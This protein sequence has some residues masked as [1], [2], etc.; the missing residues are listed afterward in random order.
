MNLPIRN[1]YV[2]FCAFVAL[3][4]LCGCSPEN[5]KAKFLSQADEHFK[6]G[7]Y[8]LA[9][10]D[11]KNALQ[12]EAENP[13]AIAQLGT[14]YFEQGRLLM[15][16][17][18]LSRASKLQ[19]ANFEVL[20]N[21]IKTDLTF[22]D[23]AAAKTN[24]L[25]ILE[26]S[27]QNEDGPMLLAQSAT[28]PA[29]IQEARGII[30]KLPGGAGDSASANLALGILDLRENK[31]DEAE[32]AF[33]KSA[34]INPKFAEAH[35]ALAS[36][37]L[38]KKD[39]IKAEVELKAAAELSAPRS[40]KRLEY[41]SF[42]SQKGDTAAAKQLLQKLV[43]EAP[44]YLP[45]L[46][47]MAQFASVEKKYDESLAVI[48]KVLAKDSR[49]PEAMLL[50][51]RLRMA[52]GEFAVAIAELEKALGIFATS[53]QFIYQLGLAQV[54]QG[55]MRKAIET[56]NRALK[57]APNYTE[58]S[59]L[60]AGLNMRT[61][62]PSSAIVSLKIVVQQHP[63]LIQPRL[64]L[65]D[66]YRGQGNFND[67][68]AVFEGIEK[69]FP[70][71]QRTPL[72]AGQVY[73]QQ[74]RWKEARAAL[75]LS[76][77]RDPTSQTTIEQLI[78]LEV[79][80]NKFTE[81]H[82]LVDQ[83]IEKKPK[84]A[85]NYVT[86]ARVFLAQKDSAKAEESLQKSI[87][88]QPDAWGTYFMLAQLYISTSQ[89]QK[90]IDNLQ[91]IL[92]ANPKDVQS[93]TLLALVNDQL[94]RYDAALAAYE[95]ILEV[96][97][98]SGIALNNVAFLYADRF[99]QLD[100]ALESAQKA[101]DLFPKDAN[102]ADTL[103]WVLVRKGQYGR[104]IVLLEE[105]A[106]KLPK[107]AEIQY[108][109]GVAYYQF[110]DEAAAKSALELA[111]KSTESYTWTDDAKKRLTFLSTDPKRSDTAA[112]QALEKIVANNPSDTVALIRLGE[113]QEQMGDRSAAIA[114]HEAALKLSPTN[115]DVMLR[116]IRIYRAQKESEKAI[117]IAKT[118]R[119]AAPD[120]IAVAI[121]LGGLAFEARDFG[122]S[123]S[124]LQEADRKQPNNASTLRDLAKAGYS[125]GQIKET[126]G[127]LTRSLE[128]D[129]TSPA[130]LKAKEFLRNIDLA[131]TA[132]AGIDPKV[133]K[134]FEAVANDV[135]AMMVTAAGLEQKR[136]LSDAI[137]K[138]EKVL[139]IYPDF[140]PAKR[141]LAI[142][143]T[144]KDSDL[145]KAMEY[146]NKARSVYA[147]D[148]ELTK[149]FGILLHRQGEFARVSTLFKELAVK[150]KDDAEIQFY[151]GSAQAKLGN[152]APAQQYLNRALQL[153][154]KPDLATEAQKLLSD[155]K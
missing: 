119:K 77:K 104:A 18:Y 19:P 75:D 37:Y 58:A 12:Q 109:L 83:L 118:A 29:S 2:S 33:T 101:R 93:L 62:D 123:L 36:I 1:A 41:I 43:Q 144:A 81:A 108:H 65:A 16:K 143:L 17:P 124:L 5:K 94:K 84:A 54:A 71:N 86:R 79:T 9:E 125:V 34:A 39:L 60:L 138:Y 13:K 88:L 45:A 141:R 56:L 40:S 146:A 105:S 134:S 85:D 145:K 78:A 113:I 30:K 151:L 149:A 154:L 155:L 120:N 150:L 74:K 90:A 8:D 142:L 10:I 99:N 15:A 35:T 148:T 89:Q 42:L 106:E 61:G 122:Y 59:V 72:L 132:L 102:V 127:A 147:D 46:M 100:K 76:L 95:K 47:L 21:L 44:D 114:S 4:V 91:R 116:L 6:V 70:G 130:A 25:L 66:A 133:L 121:A 96:N 7:K 140:T 115:V 14:I 20:S 152:K 112:R 139:E 11:Y 129:G 87:E 57:I 27:P 135:P 107:S 24:A 49:Y 80:E 131:E 69:D 103:A 82:K 137:E 117:A 23:F 98:K 64:L 52:K 92:T 110:G 73:M 3:F 97:P 26:K 67:A 53:P 128:I 63:E 50:S 68:L 153:K 136:E 38:L 126:K 48:A 51:A 32:K 55:D 31:P 28:N 111:T 22:R